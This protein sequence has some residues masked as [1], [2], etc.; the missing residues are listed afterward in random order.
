MSRIG[1]CHASSIY[2][3]QHW[4]CVRDRR[5]GAHINGKDAAQFQ[6]S[7]FNQLSAVFNVFTRKGIFAT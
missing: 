5:I 4:P 3:V 6:L 1:E 2:P 7:A